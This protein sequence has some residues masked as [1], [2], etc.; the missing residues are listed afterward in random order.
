MPT[1]RLAVRVLIIT[2]L[3]RRSESIPIS[4]ASPLSKISPPPL[5]IVPH[6]RAHVRE[7]K[8][9]ISEHVKEWKKKN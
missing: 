3:F 1:P 4:F 8:Q 9:T 2:L 6:K 7:L 5:L